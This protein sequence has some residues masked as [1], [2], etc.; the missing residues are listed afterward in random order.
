MQ[1]NAFLPQC[2]MLMWK[3]N[4]SPLS[5]RYHCCLTLLL[6]QIAA[7]PSGPSV[8]PNR[9]LPCD[10]GTLSAH[11]VFPGEQFPCMS[12]ETTDQTNSSFALCASESVQPNKSQPLPRLHCELGNQTSEQ[13]TDCSPSTPPPA[14]HPFLQQ[15]SKPRSDISQTGREEIPLEASCMCLSAIETTGEHGAT[16]KPA[17]HP[18]LELPAERASSPSETRGFERDVA[19]GSNELA[20]GLSEGSSR[21]AA[22][23]EASAPARSSPVAEAETSLKAEGEALAPPEL[24]ESNSVNASVTE[25]SENPAQS[26]SAWEEKEEASHISPGTLLENEPSTSSGVSEPQSEHNSYRNLLPSVIFLSGVVS[27]LIVLQEPTALILIGLIF[28]WRHL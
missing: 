5:P 12:S 14:S 25:V 10:D 22:H 19:A 8:P 7:H 18:R 15:N 11:A 27:L 4:Y 13:H 23:D 21:S 26:V 24:P 20:D 1:Y 28:I 9:E 6:Q 17:S 3:T 2:E 16:E